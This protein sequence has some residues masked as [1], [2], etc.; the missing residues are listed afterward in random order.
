M[1]NECKKTTWFFKVTME[2]VLQKS[3]MK[4]KFNKVNCIQVLN[5]VNL[6]LALIQI[7]VV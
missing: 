7:L 4:G 2:S 5:I 6:T 1:V 3:D